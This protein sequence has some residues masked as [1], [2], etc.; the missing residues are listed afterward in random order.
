MAE[1]ITNWCR[2]WSVL[3]IFFN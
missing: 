1:L 3:F 2:N